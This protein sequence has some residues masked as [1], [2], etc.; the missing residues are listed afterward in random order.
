MNAVSLLPPRQ[1]PYGAAGVTGQW[2]GRGAGYRHFFRAWV[3]R[4]W[5]GH[6]LWPQEGALQGMPPPCKEPYGDRSGYPR[7]AGPAGRATPP[8]P[9]RRE[10][11]AGGG[12]P[13]GAKSRGCFFCVPTPTP[14]PDQK[15]RPPGK[16]MWGANM[17]SGFLGEFCRRAMPPPP[18]P[19][20][21]PGVRTAGSKR[22][23]GGG[24]RGNS[25]EVFTDGIR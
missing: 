5:R 12:G 20:L 21:C 24:N 6:V 1:E 9:R 7:P 13:A 14:V 22:P 4:A 25:P 10:G 18:P 15:W 17:P 16:C 2:R 19:I 23:H 11:S 3:A 8:P